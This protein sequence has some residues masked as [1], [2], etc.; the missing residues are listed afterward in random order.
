MNE[1]ILALI[2]ARLGSSRF[3]RKPLAPIL[4]MPMIGHVFERIRRCELLT[5]TAVC[6]C[7][8]E[9]YRSSN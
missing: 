6:T 2:P 7:D 3:P 4:G 5:E 8:H 9:M 1:K